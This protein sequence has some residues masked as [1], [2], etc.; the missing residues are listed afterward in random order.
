M[1]II[2]GTKSNANHRR[3]I[4]IDRKKFANFEYSFLSLLAYKNLL[5]TYSLI[6][7]FLLLAYFIWLPFSR[8]YH[9][10]SLFLV[11]LAP[12]KIHP[13]F[14]SYNQFWKSCSPVLRYKFKQNINKK[15]QNLANLTFVKKFLATENS[16]SFFT[17]EVIQFRKTSSCRFQNKK[18]EKL[19]EVQFNDPILKN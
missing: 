17:I 13:H 5:T 8:V 4:E 3:N 15:F 16:F 11:H 9:V 19:P 14:S 7:L 2:L 10:V 12:S 6:N 1:R 18:V